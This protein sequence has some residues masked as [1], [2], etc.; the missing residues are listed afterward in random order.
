MPLTLHSQNGRFAVYGW[1]QTW[2]IWDAP[3]FI[4]I[5]Q[6]GY[7][8][9]GGD[10]TNWIAF[11][12]LLPFVFWIFH[13]LTAGNMLVSGYL[14]AFI[15]SIVDAFALTSLVRLDYGS[16]TAKR[17]VLF[18]FIFP[19]SLFLHLPYTESLFLA[20]VLLSFVCM[21]L[22][23]FW[24]AFIFAALATATRNQGLAL[25]PAII[26]ELIVY[27]RKTLKKHKWLIVAGLVV[28]SLGFA[29]YL[30][31]NYLLFGSIFHFVT[32]ERIRWYETTKPPWYGFMQV[33]HA[34]HWRHGVDAWLLVY[35]Q[36][37]AAIF[38][39][40]VVVYS[41]VR[42]RTS[43]A[44]YALGAL[45]VSTIPSFWISLP[46][47]ILIMFPTYIMLANITKRKILFYPAVLIILL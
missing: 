8:R 6:Y 18:L 3:H 34:I 38:G 13:W 2:N 17:A 12:P 5:A 44:V 37:I 47:Y 30:L 45:I 14:V 4:S 41:F 33:V 28:P 39:V 27:H 23:K 20:L 35:S 46:R 29:T 1:L 21:R 16:D 24:T 15:A 22:E 11:Y 42:L 7:Q 25:I 36:I 9:F 26:V 40:V 10:A 32:V 31:I 43:Y 19:T